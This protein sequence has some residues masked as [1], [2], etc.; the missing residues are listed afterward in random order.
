LIQISPAAWLVD[1]TG[2]TGGMEGMM[3]L[4]GMSLWYSV[5][6]G[7]AEAMAREIVYENDEGGPFWAIGGREETPEERW[8]RMRKWVIRNLIAGDKGN[9][10]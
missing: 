3:I 5:A 9:N 8:S 1:L 7:I 6:I 10:Q 2:A 4:A